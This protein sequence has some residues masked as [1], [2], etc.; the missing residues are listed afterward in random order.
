[1]KRSFAINVAFKRSVLFCASLAI[2]ITL[3][4]CVNGQSAKEIAPT[5]ALR[6]GLYKGSPSSFLVD[7]TLLENRG[8][9]FNLGQ[10]LATSL[11]IPYE[12]ILY[13][14]NAEVL[15]AIK[16]N[17]IDL[18]FTNATPVRAQ[19]IQ[20]SKP[21]VEI[22]KGFL[23]KPGSS[24]KTF[25]EL[26]RPGVKIGF[27]AGS[28]SERELPVLLKSAALIKVGSN[29]EAIEALR[30]GNID[31]FSANKGILFEMADQLPGSQVLPGS[32]AVESIA[33]GV[34]ISRA[35]SRPVLDQF[36]QSIVG[37]G[38]LKEIINLSGMRGVVQ[39]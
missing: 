3:F 8:I 1:M 23:V 36:Y 39:R 20:F 14:S 22:D 19:F 30:S 24:L 29:G 21:F 25:E 35:D 31:A 10:K 37:S 6:M 27:S 28:S 13:K 16:D 18:V 32:I 26:D 5:G 7:G 12:P 9:G 17:Q 38:E 15:Q 33:L 4:G 11:Q 34:P 2:T